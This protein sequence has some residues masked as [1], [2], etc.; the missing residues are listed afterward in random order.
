MCC[1]DLAPNVGYLQ[2]QV[3]KGRVRHL[4]EA[5][6][7]LTEAKTHQVSLMVA[8]I[9]EQHVTFCTFSDASFASSKDN[10]SY[11]VTLV[12]ATD[13]RTLANERAVV[14]PVAWTSR[15]IS[16]VVRS[17]R[18]SWIRLFWEWLKNPGIDISRPKR[19]SEELV[20]HR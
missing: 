7:A 11:Q 4:I 16:R 8:P 18:M 15:K 20:R 9:P 12:I 2:S 19:F 13:W 14:V 10:H 6:R 1:S 5:N 17:Y 3:H